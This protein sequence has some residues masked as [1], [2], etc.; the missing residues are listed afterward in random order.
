M[1]IIGIIVL[2]YLSLKRI[3]DLVDIGIAWY[4]KYRDDK[5][6]IAKLNAYDAHRDEYASFEDFLEYYNKRGVK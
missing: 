2:G 3:F 5:Q 4:S 1:E 6:A